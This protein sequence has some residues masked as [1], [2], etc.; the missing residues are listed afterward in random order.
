MEHKIFHNAFHWHWTCRSSHKPQLQTVRVRR[1]IQERYRSTCPVL[2][3]LLHK[4]GFGIQDW[5]HVFC[6]YHKKRLLC[7]VVGSYKL[8]KQ[9]ITETNHNGN[10]ITFLGVSKLTLITNYFSNVTY[11][12]GADHKTMFAVETTRFVSVRNVFVM[13]SPIR[14]HR[15][16][17][18]D[19]LLMLDFQPIKTVCV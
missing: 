11:R 5:K 2:K 18:L 1:E 8:L 10:F 15:G 3:M 16:V 13:T 7:S 14:H 6:L 17:T 19:W 12:Q 9:R 4:P